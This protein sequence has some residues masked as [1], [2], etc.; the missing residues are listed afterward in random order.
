MK[1]H[2]RTLR[3]TIAGTDQGYAA[4]FGERAAPQSPDAARM[5]RTKEW[6]LCLHPH[7]ARERLDLKSDPD[8]RT[9]S[10]AILLVRN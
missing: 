9:I 6:K 7:G 2:G 10:R 4:V 3:K 8:E 1:T 5:I